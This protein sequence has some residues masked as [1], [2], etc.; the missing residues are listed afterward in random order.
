MFTYL[1]GLYEDPESLKR[2]TGDPR[3]LDAAGVH[4]CSSRSAVEPAGPFCDPPAMMSDLDHR[5]RLAA[6]EWLDRQVHAH[7]E[8]LPWSLLAHGFEL[9]GERVRLVSQQGIFK[10]RLL[11]EIPLSIPCWASWSFISSPSW[12]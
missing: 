5:V 11:P 3:P 12:T 1:W 10:P 7:G 9:N 2:G 6:F 8:E 4:Q